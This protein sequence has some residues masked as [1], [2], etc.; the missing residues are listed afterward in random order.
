M[1]SISS[2][3]DAAVLSHI[4]AFNPNKFIKLILSF[5]KWTNWGSKNLSNFFKIILY[6]FMS[7]SSC[8]CDLWIQLF[9]IMLFCLIITITM[10]FFFLVLDNF[11]ETFTQQKIRNGFKQLYMFA[12]NFW[13]W[14]MSKHKYYRQDSSTEN[15][16]WAAPPLVSLYFNQ[17]LRGYSRSII[18][19]TCLQ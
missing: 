9:H 10:V 5:Y 13:G 15:I 6:K 12:L 2:F 8:S 14:G 16:S 17:S 18:S 3:S 7:L 1:R 11:H 19:K 4:I